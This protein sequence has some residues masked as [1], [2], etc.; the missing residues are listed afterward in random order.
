MYY[1]SNTTVTVSML[2][3]GPLKVVWVSLVFSKRGSN[4]ESRCG[5]RSKQSSLGSAIPLHVH[6]LP[7][8]R[9]FAGK[10]VL[11]GWMPLP[12]KK[13]NL[14]SFCLKSHAPNYY[15][16]FVETQRVERGTVT[17]TSCYVQV[18]EPCVGCRGSLGSLSLSRPT[19][20]CG[21]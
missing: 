2:L 17:C 9:D 14:D 4:D 16:R 10:L 19:Y 11:C 18:L 7:D 5:L 1:N 21:G 3:N 8:R 12:L 6:G 15:P 13:A 20:S